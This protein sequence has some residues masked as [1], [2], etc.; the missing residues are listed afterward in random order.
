MQTND[1]YVPAVGLGAEE[2][3]SRA[4]EVM[5]NRALLQPLSEAGGGS[6]ASFLVFEGKG[7]ARLKREEF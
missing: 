6:C 2:D 4:A 7:T 1:F 5:E 3:W